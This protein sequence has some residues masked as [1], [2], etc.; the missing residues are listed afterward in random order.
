LFGNGGVAWNATINS[1][2]YGMPYV[3]RHHLLRIAAC[4]HKPL[5]RSCGGV[6]GHATVFLLFP[7]VDSISQDNMVREIQKYSNQICK[8]VIS[9]KF[10]F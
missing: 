5:Y 8:R 3:P 6:Q 9:F 2:V 7:P 10:G 4:A 1:S